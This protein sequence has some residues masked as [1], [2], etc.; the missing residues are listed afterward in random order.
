MATLTVV[1][2]TYAGLQISG[3]AASGG[4]DS[5]PNDGR[6]LLVVQ[7]NGGSTI[8]VTITPSGPAAGLSYQAVAGVV[9]SGT[10]KVFGPFPTQQF[11]NVN[12]QIPISYSSVTSLLVSAV[13]V[14]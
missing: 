12:G 4:G 14:T 5:M 3:V 6:T 7:N 10:I 11:N 2:P 1:T 13:Q 8:T 9:A